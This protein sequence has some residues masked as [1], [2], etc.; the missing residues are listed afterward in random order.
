MVTTRKKPPPRDP[1]PLPDWQS[2]R[3]PQPVDAITPPN[4]KLNIYERALAILPPTAP[5]E[6]IAAVI[7]AQAAEKLGD[8]MIEAAAVGRGR[9]YGA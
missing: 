7:V 9:Q 2:P 8:K 5:P 6:I 1:T 3:V 4:A